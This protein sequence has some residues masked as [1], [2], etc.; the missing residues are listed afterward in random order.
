[1]VEVSQ[2]KEF[3]GETTCRVEGL[4]KINSRWFQQNN[5]LKLSLG[6]W[7]D[8]LAE[9]NYKVTVKLPRMTESDKN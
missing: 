7:S 3:N 9:V 5:F 1:M 2:I 6:Y 4:Q 8:L